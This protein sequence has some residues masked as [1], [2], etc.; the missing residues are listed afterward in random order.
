MTGPTSRASRSVSAASGC[1]P[2]PTCCSSRSSRARTGRQGQPQVVL[3]GWSLKAQHNVFNN[4]QVGAGRLALRLQRHHRYLYVGKPGTPKEQRTP[5]N[6]GVWRDQPVAKLFEAVRLGHHQPLGAGLGRPR[7]SVHHQL[8]HQAPVSHAA[9]G[10]LRPHVR[11]GPEPA[12]LWADGK[13]A[14]HL[15]WAGGHW[16]SLR[17]GQGAHSEDRRWPCSCRGDDLSRRQLARNVSQPHLHGQPPRR[18]HQ[19]GHPGASRGRATSPSMGSI[20]CSATT[21]GFA[22]CRCCTGRTAASSSPTGTTPAN[23]TTTRRLIPAAGFTR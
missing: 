2:R 6:C 17:G 1:A 12:L 20:S 21:R 18:P 4:L 22:R 15:H 7:R 19:P 14:D 5:M 9:G 3:D 8:R 13:L 10:S 16:T 11:A 23:A